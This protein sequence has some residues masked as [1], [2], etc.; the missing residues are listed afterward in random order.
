MSKMTFP[1]KAANTAPGL[2]ELKFR[3]H[4]QALDKASRRIPDDAMPFYYAWAV[5]QVTLLHASEEVDTAYL[6]FRD[7][8]ELPDCLKSLN[9]FASFWADLIDIN[10]FAQVANE[11]AKSCQEYESTKEAHLPDS[12]N[13]PI[14]DES[15]YSKSADWQ[16]F[17][18]NA[19]GFFKVAFNRKSD[20]VNETWKILPCEQSAM[21]FNA[22]MIWALGDYLGLD[23]SQWA[24]YRQ[25]KRKGKVYDVE[26]I[27][28]NKHTN[29]LHR[30]LTGYLIKFFG[31]NS[32]INEDTILNGA[33]QWYH[34]RVKFET[35]REAANHYEIE[36]GD[37]SH[38][39]EPF[40][41]ATGWIRH[42]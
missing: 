8:Y 22:L 38:R 7:S 14:G 16:T 9:E 17:F 36:P 5:L 18:S 29:R 33:D 42:K 31:K 37:L 28:Q 2:N 26:D 11:V 10:K 4:Q 32:L 40:D 1:L 12:V 15:Q 21:L 13:I 35:I 24:K 41:D 27:M 25:L 39:I 23:M 20:R 3:A 30:E 19:T 34:A 6:K